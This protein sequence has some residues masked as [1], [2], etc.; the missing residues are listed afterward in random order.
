MIVSNEEVQEVVVEI[1]EGHRHLR[2]TIMLQSGQEFTFQE[3]TVA[4]LVRAYI[5][6]KTHP[7]HTSVRLSRQ[8]LLTRKDGFTE[9]Q[10]LE[11]T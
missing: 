10:L 6:I 1:P 11:S 8:H 7:V 3:A 5:T 2:T 4:N 9:W